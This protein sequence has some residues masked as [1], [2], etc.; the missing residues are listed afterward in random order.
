MDCKIFSNTFREQERK[1]EK[2]RE[3]ERE[4]KREKERE[5]CAFCLQYHWKTLIYQVMISAF[6]KSAPKKI[7]NM[8]EIVACFLYATVWEMFEWKETVYETFIREWSFLRE[9]SKVNKPV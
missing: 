4:R 6:D 9:W 1:R 2:Q 7:K 5:F 3:R 8:L